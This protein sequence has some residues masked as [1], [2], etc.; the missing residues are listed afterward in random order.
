MKKLLVMLSVVFLFAQCEQDD[1]SKSVNDVKVTLTGFSDIFDVSVLSYGRIANGVPPII[2]ASIV[3]DNIERREV[4]LSFENDIFKDT[5]E[6]VLKEGVHDIMIYTR[7]LY[8]G[9]LYISKTSFFYSGT[10]NLFFS[11][12]SIDVSLQNNAFDIDLQRFIGALDIR[13]APGLANPVDLRVNIRMQG[14]IKY[15]DLTLNKWVPGTAL[16][17]YN[18]NINLSNVI[19]LPI[20]PT[21]DPEIVF[22]FIKANGDFVYE[23]KLNIPLGFEFQSG[24]KL[25]VEYDYTKFGEVSTTGLRLNFIDIYE[26]SYIKLN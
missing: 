17:I 5:V 1:V 14:F 6:L 9:A 7:S 22:E 18:N 25:V 23:Q 21:K 3:I 19:I 4:L 16:G 10:P 20:W 24:K 26:D 13:T 2:T 8:P 15:Y 12:S 11:R